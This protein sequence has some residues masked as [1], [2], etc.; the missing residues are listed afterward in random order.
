MLKHQLL[1]VWRLVSIADYTSS[2]A[3]LAAS[4]WAADYDQ[5]LSPDA[6]KLALQHALARLDDQLRCSVALESKLLELLKFDA[7]ATAA[8]FAIQQLRSTP[9]SNWLIASFASLLASMVLCLLARKADKAAVRAT[10]RSVLDGIGHV[11]VPET[12]LA[13][14]IHTTIEAMKATQD[15][16]ADRYDAATTLTVV[17][18]ALLLPAMLT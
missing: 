4:R 14:S 11:D 16:V 9:V 8:L 1:R 12:W 15:V 10:V 7:T 2:A 3:Y 5:Q 6:A 17:A 18:L 13:C